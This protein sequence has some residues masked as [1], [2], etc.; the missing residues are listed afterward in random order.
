MNPAEFRHQIG[1]NPAPAA[2]GLN[3]YRIPVNYQNAAVFIGQTRP[4]MQ[5]PTASPND[6]T[7]DDEPLALPDADGGPDPIQERAA[8]R[9]YGRAYLPL[10]TNAVRNVV[11][12]G[13][14]KQTF[15]PLCES[16]LELTASQAGT[17]FQAN[18]IGLKFVGSNQMIH[19][20][21]DQCDF[22]LPYSGESPDKR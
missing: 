1:C 5:N 7:A 15:G 20:V 16:I 18:G 2:A 12:G 8:L 10:F 11:N 17:P 19:D 13:N 14:V 3:V 21:V 22:L 4:V 6:P 9:Q